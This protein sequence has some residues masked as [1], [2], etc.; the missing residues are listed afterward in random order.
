M[1]MEFHYNRTVH[2][3]EVTDLIGCISSQYSP[4]I[5][6]IYEDERRRLV[7][8]NTYLDVDDHSRGEDTTVLEY[9][10]IVAAL[11]RCIALGKD[12]L[13]CPDAMF[14]DGLGSG[15]SLDADIVLQ[16]AVLGGVVYG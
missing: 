6:E 16:H 15:C 5:A 10:D 9:D 12:S 14:E 1:S 3:G 2:D 8:V 11:N 7:H 13:C 4:W